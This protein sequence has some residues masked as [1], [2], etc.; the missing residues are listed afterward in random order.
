MGNDDLEGLVVTHPQQKGRT[1][2]DPHPMWC[3]VHNTPL[4]GTRSRASASRRGTVLMETVLVLPILTLLIFAI[5]Q[6]ALIWYAQIMTQ[7]AAYNAARA[8][9]VYHPG[10]YRESGIPGTT[11]RTVVTDKFKTIEGPCWEAA[12]RTLAWVSSSPDG[13]G[14]KYGIP[15][16]YGTSIPNSSHIA[17]QVR[18]DPDESL[19]MT[20]APVVKVTVE[21]DF[22]LHVP[23][24]G[25]M[26]AYFNKV[27]KESPSKYEVWGWSPG[28]GG[29]AKLDALHHST[30][31][32]DFIKLRA[33]AI[34]PKPYRTSHFARI[35]S[36]MDSS[37]TVSPDV[38]VKP[39]PLPIVTPIKP[40]PKPVGLDGNA[41][42]PEGGI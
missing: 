30:M 3:V 20:N 35:P 19:E 42:M 5:I 28:S 39:L 21:F 37:A 33:T 31:N 36:K 2:R 10:E 23:V 16:W 7:Y 22:P 40:F 14:S 18:I 29:D 4:G 24:I 1:C 38:T 12:C 13:G 15:G 32:V 6:F 27:E 34:L 11:I 25:R 41:Y 9:L 8:A 17:K 26:L